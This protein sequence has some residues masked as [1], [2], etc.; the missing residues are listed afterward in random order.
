M[1]LFDLFAVQESFPALQFES[2]SSSAFFMVK[3]SHTYMTTE[4]N[5]TAL[6][7]QTFVGEVMSLF[8]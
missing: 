7:I 6:T 3:P 5:P 1:G 8:F 4:K 2:I